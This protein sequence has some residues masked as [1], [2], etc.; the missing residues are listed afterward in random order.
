MHFC[1]YLMSTAALMH[2]LMICYIQ[3]FAA[4]SNSTGQKR[5]A[6]S[7]SKEE[8]IISDKT[9]ETILSAGDSEGG[10]QR[11][12]LK[13][14]RTEGGGAGFSDFFKVMCKSYCT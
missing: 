5:L 12:P 9:V 4:K 14:T 8:N 7:S 6:E 10:P 2:V 3:T 13:K 11:P 1:N